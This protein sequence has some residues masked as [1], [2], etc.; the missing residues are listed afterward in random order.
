VLRSL[1]P[2]EPVDLGE[3]LVLGQY[4]GYRGEPG[5]ATGSTVPTYLALEL[6]LDTWRWAG[7]PFYLRAGKALAAK[8]TEISVVFRDVPHCLLGR[9]ACR[10]LEQ[11]ALTMRLQ[12]AEGVHLGFMCKAPGPDLELAAVDMD[13]GYAA[14]FRRPILEAYQRVLLDAMRGERA[15][16]MRG[17]EIE[18]AWEF[19]DP[20][21]G[22]AGE[23]QPLST[24]RP[25][26]AGPPG[27]DRLLERTARR[28]F[29]LSGER[30]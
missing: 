30:S 20:L 27:A 16:F 9:A 17:D 15:L 3:R 2:L 22:G 26:S 5:V 8:T 19:V 10:G 25:G 24:Y 23:E 12:P 13:M 11:N 7:V 4:D 29:P 6:G 1:R 21:L 28:W 18:A 14:A